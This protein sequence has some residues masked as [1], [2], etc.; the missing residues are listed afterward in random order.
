MSLILT[1]DQSTSATK[2]LLFDSTGCV[3][4]RETREHTQ[5]YPKP[6]WVEHD[7]EEIWLNL[8]STVSALLTRQR[9]R[10]DEISGVS[11]TNQ[12]ETIVIFD[13][14][15]GEP[16]YP[17]IV[18]QCRRSE[19]ICAALDADGHGEFIHQRT[20]LRLDPYF[21]GSKLLWMIKN[22]AELQSKLTSKKALIGTIDTYLNYRLTKGK[23]F[24]TDSTNASRTLLYNIH[25]LQWD[26]E[27]CSFWQVPITALPEVRE[28]SAFF[29]ETDFAGVIGKS[30]PIVG[31]IGDSQAA[32]FAQHCLAP[33]DAKATLGTGSSVLLNIGSTPRFS[34]KG[35]LTSLAWVYKGE[36]TYAFEG[37]IINSASTLTWLQKQ[38]GL[39]K[40]IAEMAELAANVSDSA[41][42]YLVPAFSGLGLPH[43][44]P[45]A[46]GAIVGLSNHSDRRHI[47][48]AALD[49]IGY[50]LRDVL[51]VMQS[52]SGVSLNK[53]RVD[54]GPTANSQLMQ[55]IADMLGTEL[56]VSETP[57]CSAL[58][59]TKMGLLTLG[60]YPTFAALANDKQSSCVFSA[61]MPDDDVNWLVKGWRN[62][63]RQVLSGIE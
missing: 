59:A 47:S 49:S 9:D 58:G 14:E 60:I 35:V 21:S 41:G 16:L 31:I 5:H 57:E 17:A 7:A 45:S 63:V 42:V 53:L 29:G 2:S 40:D 10:V 34:S 11:I 27:L 50:Q 12:R 44:E 6:G 4:D 3:L 43:W 32:L 51:E 22:N 62:A 55:F 26:E 1:I 25:S 38:L 24:A 52:E 39:A 61:H 23:V 20:G 46:R 15:T 28:S 36:P 54:G 8:L 33:G 19:E 37:I 30:L 56:L 13:S 48:R 18:W